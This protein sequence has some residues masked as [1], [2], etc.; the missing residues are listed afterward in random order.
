M[1]APVNPAGD[2]VPE[3]SYGPERRNEFIG[4]I[5]TTPATA[6][7]I[8]SDLQAHQL[9]TRYRVWSVRQ[10]VHHLADSHVNSYVRFKWALTEDHPTIKAYDEGR[11]AALADTVQGDVR[12]PLL[13]LEGLHLRWVQL[14]RTMTDEQFRRSF[15]HPET[16]KTIR[17]S[18][19]L[20][21]YAWHCR[22]HVAQIRWLREQR[23]W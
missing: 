21:Y 7:E 5:E 22:H 18:E 14:L 1:D 9:D 15:Y 8:V 17:L 19:A 20:C 4:T 2:F 23:G 16:G 10:I 3:E 11:W 13:L 12:A 6:R